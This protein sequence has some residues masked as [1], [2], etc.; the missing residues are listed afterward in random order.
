M[1][2]LYGSA[3]LGIGTLPVTV[4]TVLV[5]RH[6]GTRGSAGQPVVTTY[7]LSSTLIIGSTCQLFYISLS[8]V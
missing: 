5:P 1:R 3:G 2:L 4:H 8:I 7:H 6:T